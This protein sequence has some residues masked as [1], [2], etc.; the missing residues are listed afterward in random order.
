MGPEREERDGPREPRPGA[1]YSTY[2]GIA[3]L[4]LIAIAAYNTF[5]NEEGGILVGDA[6]RGEP[7]KEFAVPDAT[8]SLEEKD[9]NVFQDDC[10][11]AENP[12]PVDDRRQPACQVTVEGAIR[13]CDF[14]D[15]P[16]V[17]SF[18]FTRGADCVGIQDVV[19]EVAARYGGRVNF[20]SVNVADDPE[21]VREIVAEHGWTMPVG[22]DR[23]GA[24]S[25]IYRIGVCP[26]VVFAYEGG[27]FADAKVK[28]EELTRARLSRSVERLLRESHRR[29]AAD[30]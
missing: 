14:F 13:V 10:E 19:D 9:A 11:T 17:I 2:V 6:D 30:R 23:D 8:T 27:I 5:T 3:F 1:R 26:T 22:Y 18:W 21:E 24:V 7:L 12:C 4:A 28:T 29:A 20:L 15:R 25:E 16:L